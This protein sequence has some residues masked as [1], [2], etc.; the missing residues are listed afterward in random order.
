MKEFQSPEFKVMMFNRIY[1]FTASENGDEQ[2]P[3]DDD[4]VDDGEIDW[5]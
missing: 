1:I 4:T 5:A 3:D 2:L